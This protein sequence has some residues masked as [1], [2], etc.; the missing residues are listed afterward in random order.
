MKRMIYLYRLL[1]PIFVNTSYLFTLVSLVYLIVYECLGRRFAFTD[2]T[3]WSLFLFSFGCILLKRLIL[4]GRL[5]E[6]ISY[7]LRFA[8][9]ICLTAALA[10]TCIFFFNLGNINDFSKKITI[11]FIIL[12][13]VICCCGLEIFN[14]YRTHMY[15]MLLEQ[16]K[17]RRK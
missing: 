8:I 13:G 12:L 2:R 10:Y 3:V 7:S 14:R 5:A 17:R 15:N 11:I 4:N 9:Y 16:Y 1:K 6:K